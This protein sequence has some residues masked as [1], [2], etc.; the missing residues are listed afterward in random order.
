MNLKLIFFNP[1]IYKRLSEAFTICALFLINFQMIEAVSIDSRLYEPSCGINIKASEDILV[2]Q[3]DTPK[4]MSQLSLNVSG[5]G[6]LV[7][8][9]SIASVT[10]NQ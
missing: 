10:V 3:W 9:I 7:R 6:A 4:G 2:L 8:S 5:E 1:E